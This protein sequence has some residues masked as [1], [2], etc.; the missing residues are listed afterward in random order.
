MA[1][2]SIP[3]T[4][5]RD[6]LNPEQLADQIATQLGLAVNPQ[7]D[8]APTT[9]VVTHPNVTAADTATIQTVINAYVFDPLWAGG[10]RT[11]LQAKAPGALASNATFLALGAPTNAQVLAQ[12]QALTRQVNAMIRL[13]SN[14]LTSTNNT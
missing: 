7:V 11:A 9:I 14:L 6:P 13:D 8:I 10:I 4:H 3:Y 2:V 5:N 12:V 1:T